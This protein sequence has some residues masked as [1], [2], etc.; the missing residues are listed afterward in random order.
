MDDKHLYG[1][2][3]IADQIEILRVF[4]LIFGQLTNC[5]EGIGSPLISRRA[6]IYRLDQVFG[7]NIL[8]M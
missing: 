4:P 7:V 6:G 8:S 2:G 1:S 3:L 5:F